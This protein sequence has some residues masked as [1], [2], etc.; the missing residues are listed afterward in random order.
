MSHS[1]DIIHSMFFFLTL[2]FV[3]VS[4]T[5]G[6]VAK[7]GNP[8]V[9][10][11]LHYSLA[12]EVP[13]APSLPLKSTREIMDYANAKVTTGLQD[14]LAQLTLTL[15]LKDTAEGQ[16]LDSDFAILKSNIMQHLRSDLVDKIN[17]MHWSQVKNPEETED[18]RI[19]FAQTLQLKWEETTKQEL[20]NWKQTKLHQWVRK[21]LPLWKG[22]EKFIKKRIQNFNKAVQHNQMV[23]R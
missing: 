12:N 20:D 13:V 14:T 1:V 8:T 10:L 5:L 3:V 19:R 16:T 11:S 21:S 4:L 6:G 22:K 23:S 7:H 18:E 2:V 17:S 15:N 9:A